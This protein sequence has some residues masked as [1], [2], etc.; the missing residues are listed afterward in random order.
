MAS[1]LSLILVVAGLGLVGYYALLGDDAPFSKAV[2]TATSDEPSVTPT[3]T[4]LWLTVPKMA[5]VEDLP[6]YSTP[7]DDE[8]ALEASLQHVDSTGFPWEEEANV[9]IAGHR[10]GYPGTKSFL[11]FWDLD[12]LEDGDEIFLTDAEGTRYT[13]TVFTEFVADPYDWSSTEPVEGKNI[14][15]LQTCTLPDYTERLIVQAELTKVEQGQD[16]PEQED[17][18]EADEPTQEAGTAPY[19]G[20]VPNEP[21][22]DGP[23]PDGPIP[24]G[25]IPDGP[26]PDA[27]LP[28]EPLP[29]EPIPD[30]PLPVEPLPVEPT[31]IEPAQAV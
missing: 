8:A 25:P 16:K 29:D 7:W 31:P 14:V 5:R 30:E 20:P 3:E 11:V 21:I 17:R 23:I 22:P 10:L 4:T 19:A 27:P 12:V 15:T 26:I 1:V 9:Y 2:S 28:D 18:E 13:Y 24:D 6:V